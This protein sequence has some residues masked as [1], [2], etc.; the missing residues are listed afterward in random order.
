MADAHFDLSGKRVF[1]AGH[2]GMVGSALVRRLAGE[3]CTILTADRAT[4]DLRRQDQV[5]AWFAANRPDVVFLAAARVGGIWANS[6][7]PA[8]FIY[9][10]L[11]I[12]ANVIDAAH[13][14][15]AAKL[16]FLGS[17]C[18]F[19]KDAPQPIPEEALLTGPLEPTNEWYAV[20]KIAGIKLA[21]AYRAQY[22][23]DFISA[24]PTNL[25]GTGDNFDLKQSHVIP[26]LI[27]KSHAAKAAGDAT[28]PIWGSGTPQREFLHVDDLADALVF[29][30]KT[31]SDGAIVNVGSG[32]EVTIRALA[33]A[34]NRVVG[35]EGELVF[36]ASKPDG[37]MRKLVD[38][39]RIHGLGW[40]HRIGLEEGLAST[41]RWFLDHHDD[42]RGLDA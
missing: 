4:M 13:R 7:F 14:N 18:I 10:N 8:E 5:V 32:E 28:M 31:Y 25:Y 12:E 11:V 2:R 42:A 17:A 22:G 33:E 37:V 24:Q 40:H 35:F 30:V 6:N 21:Q 26:A 19:P 38:V 16:L 1:V 29:L 39:T 41:Y 15:G 3:G 36:D 34:V 27:R 9:D 20:A 23:C